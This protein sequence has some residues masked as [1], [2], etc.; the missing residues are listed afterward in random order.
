MYMYMYILK[1]GRGIEP[2]RQ[3]IRKG[4]K[5]GGLLN[6]KKRKA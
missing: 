6:K 4:E 1:R 3:V 2:S 5:K